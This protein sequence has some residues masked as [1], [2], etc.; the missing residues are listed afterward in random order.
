MVDDPPSDDVQ[1]EELE[2]SALE[3]VEREEDSLSQTLQSELDEAISSRDGKSLED[4]PT[5]KRIQTA[6]P[7]N[8]GKPPGSGA[9]KLPDI[10][11]PPRS[12]LPRPVSSPPRQ[13]GSQPSLRGPLPSTP[14]TT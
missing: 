9:P 5:I 11:P 4:R 3:E 12:A 2:E 14:P 7:A 1:V 8:S 6:P 13:I 10:P